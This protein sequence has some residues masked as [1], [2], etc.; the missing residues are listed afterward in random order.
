MRED[1]SLT[2]HLY[3]HIGFIESLFNQTTDAEE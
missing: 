1:L 3:F 2:I